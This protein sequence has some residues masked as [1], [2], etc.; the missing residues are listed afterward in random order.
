[1]VGLFS[2]QSQSV[3][4]VLIIHKLLNKYD[5][6]RLHFLISSLNLVRLG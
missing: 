4:R 6:E 2:L 5:M 1:M 3:E